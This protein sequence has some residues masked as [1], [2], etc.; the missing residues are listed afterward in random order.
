[1]QQGEKNERGIWDRASEKDRS[2]Q[3]YSSKSLT[4]WYQEN[5]VRGR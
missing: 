3:Q 5:E 1:M 4:E 2:K